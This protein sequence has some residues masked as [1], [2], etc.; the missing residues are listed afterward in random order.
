MYHTLVQKFNGALLGQEGSQSLL[1]C[2][3]DQK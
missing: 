3:D 1:D 2:H